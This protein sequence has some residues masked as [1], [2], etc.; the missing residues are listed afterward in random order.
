MRTRT[1]LPAVLL[2][3]AAGVTACSGA[4]DTEASPA[5]CKEAL[6][7]QLHEASQTGK[8]GSR[9]AAC[10]G[11]D[12]KTLEKLVGE[13]TEEWMGSDDADKVVNDALEDAFGDGVPVPDVTGTEVG[14]TGISDEC[15]EWIED[16]LIDSS[17]AVDATTGY[18]ACGDLSEEELDQAIEE[19]TNE[20]IEQGAT[21]TP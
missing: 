7:K 18:G 14:T 20:L 5:A 4:S 3:L 16:E 1:V 17:D 9:P 11:I 13:V 2:A 8:K 21:A 6:A 15:R 12:T 19:V 10:T